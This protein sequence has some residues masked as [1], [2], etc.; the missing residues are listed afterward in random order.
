M[1]KVSYA[2]GCIHRFGYIIYIYI[3]IYI[4]NIFFL[5]NLTRF[6]RPP[7]KCYIPMGYYARILQ[8]VNLGTCEPFRTDALTSLILWHKQKTYVIFFVVIYSSP[9]S[10]ESTSQKFG[11]I[12][13]FY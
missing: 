8:W 12:N 1:E 6:L 10:F 7:L 4:Y 5:D 11:G 2:Y 3:Y 9:T 13:F